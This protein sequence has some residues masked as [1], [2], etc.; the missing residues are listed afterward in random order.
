MGVFQDIV[1]TGFFKSLLERSR[2]IRVT[3]ICQVGIFV[4]FLNFLLLIYQT[5]TLEVVSYSAR[6]NILL[7]CDVLWTRGLEKWVYIALSNHATWWFWHYKIIQKTEFPSHIFLGQSKTRFVRKKKYT[8]W[9]MF[10]F[11]TFAKILE[12]K[13]VRDNFRAF[14]KQ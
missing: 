4:K 5:Q 13:Y 7:Y 9:N 3:T 10:F 2:M 12:I 8:F 6:R 1:Q 14:R 11:F